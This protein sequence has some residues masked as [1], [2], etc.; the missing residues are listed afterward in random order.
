MCR[1]RSISSTISTGVWKYNRNTRNISAGA[2]DIMTATV[3]QN[4]H[5]LSPLD[6]YTYGRAYLQDRLRGMP[7]DVNHLLDIIECAKIGRAMLSPLN[8]HPNVIAFG[9]YLQKYNNIVER[10]CG[11]MPAMRH[12][13]MMLFYAAR[14]GHPKGSI[15]D[16]APVVSDLHMVLRCRG[17]FG[18][19]IDIL[20][21]RISR[22]LELFK[23][24]KSLEDHANTIMFVLKTLLIA[25]NPLCADS[26]DCSECI[27]TCLQQLQG[28][29]RSMYACIAYGSDQYGKLPPDLDNVHY[30][31]NASPGTRVHNLMVLL[32]R[33]EGSVRNM[34]RMLLLHLKTLRGIL[35]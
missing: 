26:T 2:E 33:D 11:P 24:F 19:M 35:Q 8:E 25:P 14:V 23:S 30:V 3:Q 34:A 10:Y 31:F 5:S 21:Q 28:C 1:C 18:S 7:G 12:A 4:T 9:Q 20:L 13:Q 17:H 32:T 16:I 29:R 15:A 22:R 6:L 27:F